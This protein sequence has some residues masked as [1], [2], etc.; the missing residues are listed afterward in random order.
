MTVRLQSLIIA[1]LLSTFLWIA[2]INCGVWLSWQLSGRLASI[3]ADS[4]IEAG[5]ATHV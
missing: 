1:A 4:V 3:S 2:I 5:A